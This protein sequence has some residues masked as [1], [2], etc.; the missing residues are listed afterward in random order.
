MYLQHTAVTDLL[1]SQPG[2]NDVIA[3][4]ARANTSSCP[5][6]RTGPTL[7]LV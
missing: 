5:L 1:L 6:R 4:A 7:V 3:S 2:A